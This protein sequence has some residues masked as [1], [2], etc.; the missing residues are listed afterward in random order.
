MQRGLGKWGAAAVLFVSLNALLFSLS[1]YQMTAE[2][3]AKHALRRALAALTEIE[4]VIERDYDDLRLR[5]E[6]AGPGETVTLSEYPVDIPLTADEVSQSTPE[7]LRALLLDRSDDVLYSEGTDALRSDGDGGPPRFSA[8]GLVDGWLGVLRSRN[9]LRAGI[10]SAVFAVA[11][12]ASAG[13]LAAACRGFG[14]VGA[15]GATV[16]AGALPALAAAGIIRFYLALASDSD[17]EYTQR[18]LLEVGQALTWIPLRNGIAFAALGAT[19]VVAGTAFA[20]LS[21]RRN[22]PRYFAGRV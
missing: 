1:L 5:A 3:T 19:L 2:G 21:D 22:A 10:A 13:A 17:T 12:A 7:S 11:A 4:A 14:R 8:A 16:L 15:V 20:M 6:S 9:H 18:Q